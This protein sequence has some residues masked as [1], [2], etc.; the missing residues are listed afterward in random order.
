M[1]AAR[2]IVT[3]KIPDARGSR[4]MITMA[5]C[6]SSSYT[7]MTRLKKTSIIMEM[8]CGQM[9]LVCSQIFQLVGHHA[10]PRMQVSLPTLLIIKCATA[11]PLMPVEGTRVAL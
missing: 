11:K 4:P 5:V 7:Q 10:V 6:T 1:E 2:G 3:Q 9:A 8:M